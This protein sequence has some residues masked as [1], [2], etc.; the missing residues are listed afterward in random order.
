MRYEHYRSD[1]Y[2]RASAKIHRHNSNYN[3][4]TFQQ[5]LETIRVLV[6]G[7]KAFSGLP[8][9]IPGVPAGVS[10]SSGFSQRHNDKFIILPHSDVLFDLLILLCRD[11]YWAIVA[12]N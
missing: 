9:L 5:S 6:V 1:L 8:A 2:S 7:G 4:G 11:M 10:V 3:E 12:M